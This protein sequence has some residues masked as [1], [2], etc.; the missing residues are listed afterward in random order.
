MPRFLKLIAA[1][2]A[3][4]LLL[5]GAVPGAEA[6]PSLSARLAAQMR[7][8][9]P[10]SGAY[11]RNVTDGRVVFSWNATQARILASNAKLF[12]T[13]AALARYGTAGTPGTAVVGRGR[14]RRE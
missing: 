3:S 9:G 12:T 4:G 1:V 13:S 11:V 6:A 14:L 5:A 8:A 7:T 2:L 10:S